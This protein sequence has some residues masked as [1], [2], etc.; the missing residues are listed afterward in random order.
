MIKN[1]N[2]KLS[3]FN[4]AT[5]T[6]NIKDNVFY[7]LVTNPNIYLKILLTRTIGIGVFT[8]LIW[9]V[10]VIFDLHDYTVPATMHS[11]IGI[12]IGLLLVF[13]TNTAYDRWW[14]GRKIIAS[15]SSEIS[16]I[17][18]R[19]NTVKFTSYS[20]HNLENVKN[21]IEDFLISLKNFITMKEENIYDINSFEF[22]LKQKN[23]LENI[24]KSV[25]YIEDED[26]IKNSILNSCMKLMEYSSQLERIKNTPIPMSYVFHIK[27]SVLIYLITLPFGM[28]HDLGFA[29]IP[30]VMLI[31]Y[32]IAGVEIISSEI[33]NPFAGEPNDLPIE[34]LFNK[35]I[36]ILKS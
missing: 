11:L 24:F 15:L 2:L 22:E 1:K 21:H 4:P 27:V 7:K 35:M 6:K 31:Y 25:K 16:I 8:F 9:L 18:A 34:D 17:S 3:D 13:R 36:K 10:V 28:F 29:A 26:T 23:T 19:L 5:F 30:L 20:N 33:E 12:V 32:I 14:D